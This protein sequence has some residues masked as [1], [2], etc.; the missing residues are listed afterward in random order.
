LGIVAINENKTT[1]SNEGDGQ[2]EGGAAKYFVNDQASGVSV[3]L[4]TLWMIMITKILVILYLCNHQPSLNYTEQLA[5][6]Q[7]LLPISIIAYKMGTTQ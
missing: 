7:F 3:A 2:V 4:G 6:P 5:Y 1:L